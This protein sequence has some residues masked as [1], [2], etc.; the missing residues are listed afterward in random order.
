MSENPRSQALPAIVWQL[1]SGA[2]GAMLSRLF[3]H[4]MGGVGAMLSRPF[5]HRMG[6]PN[7]MGPRKH[8]GLDRHA[9]AALQTQTAPQVADGPRKHGTPAS[10]SRKAK[11]HTF[12]GWKRGVFAL[13]LVI[14]VAAAGLRLLPLSSELWLDELWSLEFA[15]TAHSPLEIWTGAGHHHDNNHKLNTLVLYFVPDGSP[16]ALFRLHSFIAGLVAVILA[17]VAARRRSVTAALFAAALFAVEG[18]F[19]LCSAEARGYALAIALAI[20]AYLALRNY[21]ASGSRVALVLFW[22]SVMLGFLAHLTFL[23]CYLAL[24][25]WSVYHFGRRRASGGGEVVPL[26]RCHAVPG[27]FFVLLYLTDIRGMELGGGPVLPAWEVVGSLLAHGVGLP[28]S[29]ETAWISWPVLLVGLGIT[30]FGLWQLRREGSDEWVFYGMAIIG[31]PLV[32]VGK[33]LF[34]ELLGQPPMFLYERYF[35]IPFAFFLLLVAHVL[36][37]VAQRSM[38]GRV[39]VVVA[40]LLVCVGNVWRVGAFVAE[41]GRGSFR[42]VLVYVDRQTPESKTQIVVAG[43]HDFRV[44]KFVAFYERYA[45]ARRPIVYKNAPPTPSAGLALGM[46]SAANTM[47]PEG[48]PFLLVHRPDGGEAPEETVQDVNGNEYRRAAGF[49]AAKLGGWDWY[50]YQRQ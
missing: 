34:S 32:L 36:A 42:D 48:V 39:A 6:R 37:V 3:R 16:Y 14:V 1:L 31:A 26:L 17:A 46:A 30:L 40:L 33:T 38:L 43:D 9:F 49:K 45:G 12:G 13:F 29:H 27:A 22:L 47:P 28:F 5:R 7:K 10:E 50:V 21:L 18:W 19:V 24:G 4:R 35:F 25:V 20:A 41:G 11:I 44:A 23:H 8:D 2:A 15:R